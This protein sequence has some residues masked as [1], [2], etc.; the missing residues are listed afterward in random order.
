MR[1]R[2]SFPIF[3]FAMTHFALTGISLISSFY[4]TFPGEP[5][6][7]PIAAQ[8]AALFAR[9]VEVLAFPV[10]PILLKVLP[11]ALSDGVLGWIWFALNS[12]LWALVIVLLSRAI[13]EHLLAHGKRN[14]D[15]A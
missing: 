10:L 6:F 2:A 9:A 8:R 11:R 15:A 5:G 7:D 1:V 14:S 13:R 4:F 3:L 12:L